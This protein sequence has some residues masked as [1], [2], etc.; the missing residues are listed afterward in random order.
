[1]E[2][3]TSIESREFCSLVLWWLISVPL[4]WIAH[5]QRTSFNK[6]GLQGY[7]TWSQNLFPSRHQLL[8]MLHVFAKLNHT[9][10]WCAS[11]AFLCVEFASECWDVFWKNSYWRFG[12][13][14]VCS[15]S[16]FP[17]LQIMS[18]GIKCRDWL[19]FHTQVFLMSWP[20]ART[21][22]CA[23]IPLLPSPNDVFVHFMHK[24]SQ[25]CHQISQL[26]QPTHRGKRWH[27]GISSGFCASITFSWAVIFCQ[28]SCELWNGC[29]KYQ[30]FL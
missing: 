13:L 8:G 2:E 21:P 10:K 29:T 12:A 20:I 23:F 6:I 3:T 18:S 30:W 5:D 1:M 28:Q 11:G 14:W 4:G 17:D 22:T 25:K 15:S 16:N 19:S 24:P 7:F 27:L 26:I 9:K